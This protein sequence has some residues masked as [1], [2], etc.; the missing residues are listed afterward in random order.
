MLTPHA[1]TQ[2]TWSLSRVSY[3]VFRYRRHDQYTDMGLSDF[4]KKAT[5]VVEKG[6]DQVA[7]SLSVHPYT[8]RP[9]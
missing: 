6:V 4:I 5:T 1:L 2:Y 9:T 8:E 3:S 7:D